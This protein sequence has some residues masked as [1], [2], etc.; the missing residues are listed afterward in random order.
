MSD[1]IKFDNEKVRLDLLSVV[2]LE[3]TAKV[4]TFGARKY[5]EHNWRRGFK[6]SRLIAAAMRH[7]FAFI[8]GEDKDPETG[9]SN[10]DHLACCVMFLQEHEATGLGVD[11]RFKIIQKEIE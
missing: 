3:R 10:L 11:D 1:A 2:A 7:L 9:L 5:D 6:W 4:L 8:R